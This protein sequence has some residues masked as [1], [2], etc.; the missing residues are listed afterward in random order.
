LLTGAGLM[1]KS[2]WLIRLQTEVF[3][4]EHVLETNINARQIAQPDFY[5]GELPNQIEALPGVQAA[6]AFTTAGRPLGIVGLPAPAGNQTLMT[7]VRITP[8]YKA[9]AGVRL[10]SGRWLSDEDLRGAPRVTVVNESL[11][12]IVAA[13]YPDSGPILGR[14]IDLG[15]KAS[16]NPIVVGVVSALQRRPDAEPEPQMFVLSSWWPLNGIAQYLVRV[17]GDPMTLAGPIQKIVGRTPRVEMRGTQ[18]AEDELLSGLAPRRFQTMLLVTFAGLALLLAMAGAYGVLSYGVTERTHEIGVRV[19]IG[20]QR[21][22]VL[23]MVLGRA[24]RLAGMGIGIG[25]IASASLSRLIASL[26]YGVRPSDPWTYAAT[27]LV[28]FF[29][30]ILAAYLPARRA[31]RVDPAVALRYE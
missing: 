5:L 22:D 31:M 13:L 4:P 2:L 19:A 21:M 1:L 6:A 24:A 27:G 30:A 23:L 14:Q 20:A 15:G 11:M 16:D 17:A 29:V 9:A 28:L 7:I 12:R 8:H 3:A 10:V 26:L 25:V 18:T